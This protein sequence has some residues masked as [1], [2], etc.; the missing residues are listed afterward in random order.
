MAVTTITCP[1]CDKVIRTAKVLPAG[2]KVKC[3][4]CQEIFAV[5]ASANKAISPAKPKGDPR[6]P[7]A[8]KPRPADDEDERRPSRRPVEDDLEDAEE[9]PVRKPR[10]PALDDDED[11]DEQEYRPRKSARAKKKSSNGLVIGLAAGGAGLALVVFLVLAFAWPGFLRRSETPG[12]GPANPPPAGNQPPAFAGLP[13]AGGNPGAPNPVPVVN[14]PAGPN[15]APAPAGP[16]PAGRWAYR[17][18]PGDTYVYAAN[19]VVD[20][21]DST[22]TYKGNVDLVVKSADNN[23]IRLTPNAGLPKSVRNKEAHFG[24]PFGPPPF[25]RIPIGPPT[26]A[27]R[28]LA[29]DPHG[30]VQ[31]ISSG[32]MSLPYLL[33]Y[34]TEWVI[35]PL[36]QDGQRHWELSG[37]VDISEEQ[38]TSRFSP[39]APKTQTHSGARQVV[40]YDVV[41]TTDGIARVKKKIEL[42]STPQGAR[43]TSKFDLEGQGEFTFDIRAG[44]VKACDYKGK[45]TI[46]LAD[47]NVSAGLPW[48]ISYR[49]LDAAELAALRKKQEEDRAK[50]L[51]AARKAAE[52]KPISDA[53]ISKALTDLKST[54]VFTAKGAAGRLAGSI[55][56]EAR[57][58]EVA[59][60]LEATLQEKDG[61]LRADAAKALKVWGTAKN[62]PALVRTLGDENPFAR[63]NAGEALKTMG[64]AAEKAVLPLLQ[65]KDRT[66]RCEACKVLAAVGT[67]E[68]LPALQ[69]AAADSDFF[70]KI[71][72]EKAVKAV[73]ARKGGAG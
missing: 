73:Q 42:K 69:A 25:P 60:A 41:D 45:L 20:L 22:E 13:P 64:P 32:V 68:S 26:F 10:R 44:V 18:R 40:T 27:T 39:F 35:E 6:L 28:E 48:T 15:V 11:E 34:V 49:L 5:G 31:E 17:F 1:A 72:A 38:R 4:Q 47:K 2:Q 3:P 23:S 65:Q 8:R 66:V 51:E 9:V 71:E 33:G 50:A 59:A 61:F 67:K 37:D 54:N 19:I 12:G 29:I 21:P 16:I 24:P 43:G 58:E 46:T 7:P 55:V 70:V 36:P 14:N 63:Q 57:R 52:P 53:E 30:Q 62:I 56:V